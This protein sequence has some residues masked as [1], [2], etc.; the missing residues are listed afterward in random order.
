MRNP[1]IHP[2][3][4]VIVGLAQLLLIVSHAHAQLTISW[5]TVDGGGSTSSNGA[6]SISGTTGQPDASTPMTNG[7]LSMTGGFWPGA[8]PAGDCPSDINNDNTVDVT[9]LLAVITAWGSCPLPC[10][11]RCAADIAPPGAGD[12]A[13]NVN[14]LLAV[15]TAWGACP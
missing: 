9:D 13:V 12:C 2:F 4:F 11:P 10:P 1:R 7:A 3:L 5:Y 6:L 8:T 14:D 15:I